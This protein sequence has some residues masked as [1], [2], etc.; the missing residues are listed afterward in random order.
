M[1]GAVSSGHEITA[2]PCGL[3]FQNCACRFAQFKA[4]GDL[5]RV[6]DVA[7][8]LGLVVGLMVLMVLEMAWASGVA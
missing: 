6:A 5:M 3:D 2:P 8:W 7:L 4:L 1:A